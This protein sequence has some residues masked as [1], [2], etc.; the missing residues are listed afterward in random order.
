MVGINRQILIGYT[1]VLNDTIPTRKK[2]V[3]FF[4]KGESHC[5]W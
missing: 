4:F 2:S 1:R 5:E 3:Q